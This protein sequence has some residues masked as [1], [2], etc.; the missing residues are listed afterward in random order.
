MGRVEIERASWP[1]P[2]A[3]WVHRAQPH[4]PHPHQP[5]QSTFFILL[6]P[7]TCRRRSLFHRSLSSMTLRKASTLVH[8]VASF[9]AA[10]ILSSARPVAA[11]SALPVTGTSTQ[12]MAAAG[13]GATANQGVALASTS[14]NEESMYTAAACAK[15]RSTCNNLIAVCEKPGPSTGAVL[16]IQ[17]CMRCTNSCHFSGECADEFHLPLHEMRRWLKMKKRCIV[18]WRKLIDSLPDSVRDGTPT[19]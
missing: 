18:A 16:K 9:V 3:E 2:L 7:C 6:A 14:R 19:M 4:P 5:Y 12:S 8:F 17:D 11:M 13:S 10:A 1:V 15:G